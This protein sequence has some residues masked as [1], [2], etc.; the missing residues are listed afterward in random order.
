MP[1]KIYAGYQKRDLRE[2]SVVALF[3]HTFFGGAV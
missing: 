1:A 3:S 2:F